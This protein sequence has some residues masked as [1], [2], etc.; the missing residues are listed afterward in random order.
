[1][2]FVQD[3]G[4]SWKRMYL[5]RYLQQHLEKLPVED[6]KLVEIKNLM[7]LLSP[8][9]HRLRLRELQLIKSQQ[10]LDAVANA[11]LKAE[12]K[13]LADEEEIVEVTPAPRP[14]EPEPPE[15]E[16]KKKKK[17]RPESAGKG[18]KKDEEPPAPE[19]PQPRPLTPPTPDEAPPEVPDPC[20]PRHDI[21]LDHIN[22]E[23]VIRN[24]AKLQE[25]TV[26][27]GIRD[28]GMEY[29]RELFQFSVQDMKNLGRGLEVAY[30][31]RVF[32]LTRS[33]LDDTLSPDLVRSLSKVI[34]LKILDLSHCRI[35]DNTACALGHL[36]TKHPRVELIDLTNNCIGQRGAKG[37]AYALQH[38]PC[39][40]VRELHLR[41]NRIGD[42]GAAAMAAM[43]E[44]ARLP[45]I[46]NLAA[47]DI[48]SEGAMHMAVALRHNHT[49]RRLNLSNNPLGDFKSSNRDDEG[50][51]GMLGNQGVPI[52]LQAFFEGPV[53]G[54]VVGSSCGQ[55][56]ES[57]VLLCARWLA[58]LTSCTGR[59][60][61][62]SSCLGWL[63]CPSSFLRHQRS[64]P[65]L[66][67]EAS[68]ALQKRSA[69]DIPGR[70]GEVK[71]GVVVHLFL[72]WYSCVR[73]LG[74]DVSIEVLSTS[75]L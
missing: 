23:P 25:F 12:R 32:R 71:R 10:E 30:A 38:P 48:T 44:R 41:L 39:A 1:M 33:N 73:V 24:L 35:G 14:P 13:K 54:G 8:Y 2:N 36:I 46:L 69:K 55:G 75:Q 17:K 22:L 7:K 51:T 57:H 67:Q 62:P 18:K 15:G 40:P 43:L 68:V 11:E 45:S 58:C 49:L 74:F 60:V 65:R 72:L 56:A 19:V 28:C 42:G 47:C 20:V 21:P 27:Y 63:D 6:Y 50:V 66:L 9:V 29:R 37:L 16:G 59:L 5:E 26:A 34:R 61:C 53:S 31:L 4:D 70:L 64:Q 3:Y 52:S